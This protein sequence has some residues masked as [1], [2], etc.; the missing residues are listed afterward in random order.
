MSH[1]TRRGQQTQ[2]FMP[3]NFTPELPIVRYSAHKGMQSFSVFRSLSPVDTDRGE[4]E[5]GTG[6]GND[7]TGHPSVTDGI[8]QI[9]VVAVHL[10]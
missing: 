8:A 2:P 9:P 1:H 7:I 4:I 6:T 10:D 5:D 3:D